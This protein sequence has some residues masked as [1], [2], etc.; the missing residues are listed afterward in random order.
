MVGEEDCVMCEY[1]QIMRE[2]PTSPAV[3][4]APTH[5][6]NPYSHNK[7]PYHHDWFL[8]HYLSQSSPTHT[9]MCFHPCTGRQSRTMVCEYGLE[10]NV[11]S[12]HVCPDSLF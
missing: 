3:T 8:S 11:S 12:C 5:Y 4:S 7:G 2:K 6:Y 1:G 9:R 10:K